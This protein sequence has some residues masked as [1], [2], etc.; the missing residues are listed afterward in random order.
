MRKEIFWNRILHFLERKNYICINNIFI[1]FVLNHVEWYLNP[2]K[3]FVLTSRYEG[4][5]MC[6]VEALQ[7][8]VPC[9]SFDIKIGP[10]EVINHNQN[11]ILISPFEVEEMIE[12]INHLI[13]NPDRL[14]E[15]ATNTMIGFERYQDAYI[16]EHWKNI[17]NEL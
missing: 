15:L 9:V 12:E 8:H 6:L 17:L 10:S 4:F 16:V 7:M 1:S 5:G 13:E 11:G 2:A 14:E 3:L